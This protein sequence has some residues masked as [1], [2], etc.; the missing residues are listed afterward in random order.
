MLGTLVSHGWGLQ[1]YAAV[2]V[3]QSSYSRILFKVLWKDREGQLI[4]PGELHT[5][6]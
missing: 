3:Q 6:S 1:G 4:W 5:V 2:Y